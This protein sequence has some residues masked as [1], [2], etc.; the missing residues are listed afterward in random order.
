MTHDFLDDE[1]RKRLAYADRAETL[2][3]K[4]REFRAHDSSRHCRDRG[5]DYEVGGRWSC[6]YP[7][8]CSPTLAD[9][10]GRHSRKEMEQATQACAVCAAR[11]NAELLKPP[12][13]VGS[14]DELE[15]ALHNADA[16]DALERLVCLF[17]ELDRALATMPQ[18]RA[19]RHA[20]YVL[21][22]AGRSVKP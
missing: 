19:W 13:F 4:T 21:V 9:G 8:I 17:H 6:E 22:Q 7:P 3:A 10:T 1:Q 16:L 14:V 12:V 20:K 5:C 2:E 15:K 18:Q 11:D